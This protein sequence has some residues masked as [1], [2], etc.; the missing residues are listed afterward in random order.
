[1]DL[2]IPCC[3]LLLVFVVGFVVLSI[4]A[5]Q[6]GTRLT[7][8]THDS[9]ELSCAGD[10]RQLLHPTDTEGNL[11][12]S[13]TYSNRPYLYFF[14]WTK[15]LKALN[16]P[17]NLL[18]GRPFV[19]PT[20]QVCVEQCPIQTTYYKLP[21][22]QSHRVC[23]YDVD[24]NNTDNGMLVSSGRCASYIIASKPV[25]GRCVPKQIGNLANS[26]IE[27]CCLSRDENE[28]SAS[29]LTC[30]RPMEMDPMLPCLIPMVNH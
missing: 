2:D 24:A 21:N 25:F 26:I 5:F 4:F 1:M 28:S 29:L 6:E 12:G 17:A 7:L 20:Q 18:K 22:Y 27:V 23:T 9:P 13:G 19:C 14:D 30:R 10:P 15:C 3:I 16:V 8:S 11:C